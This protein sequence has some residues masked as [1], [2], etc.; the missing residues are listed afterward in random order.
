MPRG[1]PNKKNDVL[2]SINDELNSTATIKVADKAENLKINEVEIANQNPLKVKG[3]NEFG[4]EYTMEIIM[5][6]EDGA[7]IF[8]IPKKDPNFEYRFLADRKENLNIKTSNNLLMKGGWQICPAKHLE[9][10]GITKRVLHPDGSYRVGE[11]VLAFMPKKFF[12]RKMTEDKKKRDTAM[13]GIAS[14]VEKGDRGRVNI[15]GV[16]GIQ[17]GR[18]DGGRVVFDDKARGSVKTITEIEYG[19][20][21]AV[22]QE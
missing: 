15:D 18:M 22:E 1:I 13:K 2:D 19:T 14:L 3:A 4:D 6:N 17:P 9:R 21:T 20:H 8:R 12:E 7:D 5:D 10:I 11:L 16:N